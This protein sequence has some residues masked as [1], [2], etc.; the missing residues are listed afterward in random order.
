[1]AEGLCSSLGTGV[2]F[3]VRGFVHRL[4]KGRSNRRI[5]CNH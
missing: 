4:G 3:E 2:E 1:M 5:G